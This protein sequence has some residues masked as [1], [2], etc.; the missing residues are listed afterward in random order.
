MKKAVAIQGL[1]SRS[2]EKT[3]RDRE[4]NLE[5]SKFKIDVS[6]VGSVFWAR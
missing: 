4:L 3:E 2:D 1:R 6:W 5:I